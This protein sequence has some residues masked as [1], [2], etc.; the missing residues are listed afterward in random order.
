M[1]LAL[2]A[3]GA[4][5]LL[6]LHGLPG[7]SRITTQAQLVDRCAGRAKIPEWHLVKPP[8]HMLL[9]ALVDDNRRIA[10]SN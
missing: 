1:R 4:A 3:G 8:P 10:S 9:Q 2:C 6:K 5:L 7:Y